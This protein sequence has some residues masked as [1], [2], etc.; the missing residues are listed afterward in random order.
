MSDSTQETKPDNCPDS[1]NWRH[2]YPRNDDR[3]RYCG[4]SQPVKGVAMKQGWGSSSRLSAQ[5]FLVDCANCD[6]SNCEHYCHTKAQ[7]VEGQQAQGA[8]E[9]LEKRG[10]INPILKSY[11]HETPKGTDAVTL[12]EEYA[13][14]RLA[15]HPP[16]EPSAHGDELLPC[17]FCGS[18]NLKLE[19]LVDEDDY[20]VSCGGCEIQQIANYT[21]DTAIKKWNTRFAL[22]SGEGDKG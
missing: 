15:A 16:A 5:C 7:Q 12:F 20:F 22:P 8:R 6:R 21:R 2:H 11:G 19:N 4:K 1:P 14:S 10:I 3:C 17:P 18:G 13:L 9:W